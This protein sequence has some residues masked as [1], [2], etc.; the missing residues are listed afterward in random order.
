MKR[1]IHISLLLLL[2]LGWAGVSQAAQT[3]TFGSDASTTPFITDGIADITL[4]I[5]SGNFTC[6][7]FGIQSTALSV[8]SVTDTGGNTYTLA[9]TDEIADTVEV[10]MYCGKATSSATAITVTMNSN[11]GNEGH[12]FAWTVTESATT[13]GNTSSGNTNGTSHSSGAVAITGSNSVMVGF[14]IFSSNSAPTIDA[15]YTESLNRQSLTAGYRAVTAGDTMVNTTGGNR[16]SATILT[17]I[18]ASSVT[19]LTRGLLLGV[20]P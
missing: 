1:L 18:K 13:V 12:A 19:V 16:Q 9:D 11:N 2:T 10:W 3:V 15:N 8:T 7:C 17:E 5:P 4:S 6:V 20:Y 14:T